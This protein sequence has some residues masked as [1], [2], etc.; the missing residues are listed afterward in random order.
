MSLEPDCISCVPENPSGPILPYLPVVDCRTT[1]HIETP[2]FWSGGSV[3]SKKKVNN[4][5]KLSFTFFRQSSF[6]ST[7]IHVFIIVIIKLGII[8]NLPS[9]LRNYFCLGRSS[10]DL[11]AIIDTKSC[12]AY[13]SKTTG[14][15]TLTK[16]TKYKYCLQNTQDKL[17]SLRRTHVRPR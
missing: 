6:S 9:I 8:I 3:R 5:G 7:I 11:I 14:C 13:L 17:T 1:G 2:L 15:K 10:L 16:V 12:Y 4:F